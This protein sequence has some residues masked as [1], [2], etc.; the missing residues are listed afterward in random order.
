MFKKSLSSGLGKG[1]II[2]FITL[3]IF[4][5]LNYLFH[6]VMGRMLGPEDYG[7][8][9]VLMSIMLIYN[10][11]T[12]AIQNLISRYT[13]K[14][15]FKGGENKIKSLMVKSLKKGIKISI[16]IFFIATI[17]AFPLSKFLDINFW[18]IFISN[19]VIF[20]SFIAPINKGIMQGRK[21]FGLLGWS[22]IVDSGLKLFF[23]VSLILFGFKIFGAVAGILLGILSGLVFSFYFNRDIL[24]K[25]EEKAELKKLNI[26]NSSYFV[27]T[28]VIFV[29]L[30]LDIIL[31]RKF[32]SPEIVGK[33]SVISMI[34][35]MIFF[36][37]IAISKTMF[38]LTSEKHDKNENSS[39]LFIKSFFIVL[40][41]NIISIT[42]FLFFP[43]LI[44]QILYG[45]QYIDVAYLLVYSGISLSF[46]SLVNL[47]IYYC[48]STKGI[49]KPYYLFIFL[50]IEI[51]LLYTF[52]KNITQ[53]TLAFMVSNII[54][55]IG[56]LFLIKGKK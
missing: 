12:E 40:I 19:G 38:P 17:I 45:N 28:F 13:S 50:I 36:G 47:N 44:I 37:T 23:T 20:S 18:L 46:L 33:Y 26:E 32:F 39:K 1:A 48:L 53:Y 21:K 31:A 51:I 9:A 4:N 2:L 11:P 43:K 54:M 35:K 6:F 7:V 29:I 42:A 14:F 30:S 41:L 34:G 3:N 15:N 27:T 49:R 24:E 10:I 5:F 8:L 25:K 52:N 22:L 56:S 55:F 16:I